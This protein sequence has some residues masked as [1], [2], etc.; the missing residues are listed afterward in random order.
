MRRMMYR[1]LNSRRAMLAVAVVI[2]FVAIV[3]PTC[4]MIG[5]S[6][7]GSMAWGNFQGTGFF[8]DCG[9]EYV[10]NSSPSAVVPSGLTTLLLGLVGMLFAGALMMNSQTS[11][12][13]I[14][15]H[16]SDPPPPPEDPR[17]VRLLI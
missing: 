4:Q 11:V 15:S 6:M 17:G 2:A 12:V 3:V 1:A 16:P 9:G 7:S 14:E 10:I 13:R 8:G 5:C